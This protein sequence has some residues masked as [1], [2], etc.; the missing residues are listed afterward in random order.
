MFD[1]RSVSNVGILNRLYHEITSKI[2]LDFTLMHTFYCV[3]ATLSFLV[4]LITFF[5]PLVYKDKLY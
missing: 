1:I 3:L 2:E 4:S 5:I